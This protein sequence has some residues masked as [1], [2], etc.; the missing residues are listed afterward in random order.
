[1][2]STRVSVL[3]PVR[4]A[5][6]TLEI[7]LRS[8]ERQ[9][10]RDFECLVVDDGSG[11]ASPE[12]AAR[13][14]ARDPR[15][16]LL[17]GPARGLVAA[18]RRGAAAC[19][20]P[21]IARMDADDV[22]DRRRLGCQHDALADEHLAAVG[23]HVRLFPRSALGPGM[24]NYEAWLA[25]IDSPW[26]V[27]EEAFVECPIA[28]P[29]L[30]IRRAVLEALPY[31]DMGWPED[32]DLVLRLLAKGQR[33]GVVSEPLLAWRHGDGRLSQTS[34]RY[35]DAGFTA[36][37]AAF[38]AEGI[39]ARHDHYRLWG[40]GGTGRALARALRAHGKHVERIVEMHPGRKGQT[41]HGAPVV[42][43][44][45]LGVPGGSPLLV[46]VAGR[47]PRLRIRRELARMGYRACVDYVCAA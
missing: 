9:E 33:I 17:D 4:D 27:Q 13:F 16:R 12:I 39:L 14:A 18:L 44:S 6:D 21:I 1:M 25:S 23:S 30:M 43:P 26:R 15:F 35:S 19:V 10:F 40:F 7:C 8:I 24:R 31:R 47:E 3:L 2:T 42:G 5:A 32:Y 46:S 45:D 11:D 29:T 34:P 38:L 36:C 28:H 37:K 20:A 41:I 22:M